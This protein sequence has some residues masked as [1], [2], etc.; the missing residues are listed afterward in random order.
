MVSSS[1]ESIQALIKVYHN[2]TIQERNKIEE[3]M[4]R[5]ISMARH[6]VGCPTYTD[7]YVF[8]IHS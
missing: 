8:S 7:S 4:R 3:D 6:A 5:A 2:N 1:F